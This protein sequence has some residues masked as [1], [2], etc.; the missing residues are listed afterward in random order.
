MSKNIHL[1]ICGPPTFQY[2]SPYITFVLSLVISDAFA[3]FLLGFQLLT[4]SYL[5][6]VHGVQ[7]NT[8]LLLAAEAL[9]LT[10]ILVTVLH[11]LVMGQFYS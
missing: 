7:V 5:P 8:C 3:S 11:L 2:Q 10:G 9:K 6:V 4:G 1:I